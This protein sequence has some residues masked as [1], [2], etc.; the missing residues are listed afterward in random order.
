MKEIG[1]IPPKLWPFYDFFGLDTLVLTHALLTGTG[2]FKEMIE[3]INR[4]IFSIDLPGFGDSDRVQ[5]SKDPE[6]EWL[7]ALQGRI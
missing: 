1:P 3:H 7:L 4:P 2:Q 5:F 6:P